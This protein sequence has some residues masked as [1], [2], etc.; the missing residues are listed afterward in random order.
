MRLTLAGIPELD[1]LA[2]EE[3]DESTSYLADLNKPLDFVDAEPVELPEVSS[4][5]P[6]VI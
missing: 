1:A 3:E 4:A 6:I 2:L 5:L